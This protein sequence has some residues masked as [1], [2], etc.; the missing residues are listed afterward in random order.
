MSE[1]TEE[2]ENE[3][4][5][6][7]KI[8]FETEEENLEDDFE[9]FEKSTSENNP[10]EEEEEDI[11]EK[12][13]SDNDS[14]KLKIFLSLFFSLLDGF[15][16]FVYGM[17]SKY[18]LT[19]EDIGLDDDDREEL[20]VH[21]RTQRVMTVINKIPTELMGLIHMEYMY[22][23]KFQEFNAKMKEAE[24]VEIEDNTEDI[25]FEEVNEEEDDENQEK[26]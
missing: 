15:H 23:T 17:I 12:N 16:T 10:E 13:I 4:E 8:I 9:K 24:E 14:L 11:F 26:A 6:V 7:E 18:K 20:E 25:E 5:E 3:T 19:K 21:F 2:I 22:F 1:E